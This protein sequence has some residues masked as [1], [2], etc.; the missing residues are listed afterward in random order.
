MSLRFLITLKNI[1]SSNLA[2]KIAY[3]TIDIMILLQKNCN[4]K[5][6]SRLS[7][8]KG[9]DWEEVYLLIAVTLLK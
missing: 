7:K 6:F 9:T 8:W 4:K 2:G 1:F 5:V 3:E